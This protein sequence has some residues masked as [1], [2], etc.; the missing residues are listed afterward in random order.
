MLQ[1]AFFEISVHLSPGRRLVGTCRWTEHVD[2]GRREPLVTLHF[3][4]TVRLKTGGMDA[5]VSLLGLVFFPLLL[6]REAPIPLQ[7][8]NE[9]L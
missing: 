7:F 3:D 4:L 6:V 8:S 1:L 2:P 5:R 9:K